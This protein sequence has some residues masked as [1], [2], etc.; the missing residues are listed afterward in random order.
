MDKPGQRL[1]DFVGQ[2]DG[3]LRQNQAANLI[4]DVR[5]NNGGNAEL[6]TPLVRTL[7]S[8]NANGGHLFVITGR[9]TFSAAQIFINQVERWTR[10]VFVGEPS[11]SSPNFV[12]EETELVLP[13]SGVHGSIST[14]L[15]QT[16]PMDDRKLIAPR[17]PVALS[18]ANYFANRD[19]A[20]DAV[21]RV[22]AEQGNQ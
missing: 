16:D 19:P 2:L 21:F 18:S 9:Y 4:V 8:F 12:G 10:A 13:F 22:I 1:S 17:L 7:I 11:G 5:H 15:H 20:L 14:R 3:F 6:L